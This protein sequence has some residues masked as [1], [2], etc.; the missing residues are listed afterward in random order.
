MTSPM[1][2]AVVNEQV[3][4]EQVNEQPKPPVLDEFGRDESERT[5]VLS[6]RDAEYIDHEVASGGHQTYDGGLS[7]VIARGLAEIK[8][9]RDAA[10]KL[11][12]AKLLSSKKESWKTILSQNPALA[13]DPKIVAT[14]L[15]DLGIAPK[16]QA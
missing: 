1:P 4:N 8:R 5:V 16:V 12:Q 9:T 3:S 15:A 13:I 11:A 2:I 7:Y 14:M 10:A 6:P